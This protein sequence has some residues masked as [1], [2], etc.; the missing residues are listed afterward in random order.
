MKN[1]NKHI[2]IGMFFLV[3]G[4]MFDHSQTF[5]VFLFLIIGLLFTAYGLYIFFRDK[6]NKTQIQTNPS[7][8]KKNGLLAFGGFCIVLG[9]TSDSSNFIPAIYKYA[10]GILF[11]F[12]SLVYSPSKIDKT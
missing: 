4:K 7:I 12:I 6:K 3:S 11:I 2:T 1:W 10:S 8:T 5:M 9:I